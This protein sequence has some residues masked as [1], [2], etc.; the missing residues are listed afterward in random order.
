MDRAK[1]MGEKGAK[2][3]GVINLGELVVVVEW[4][5]LQAEH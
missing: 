1:D 3:Y 4:V 5:R 2:D